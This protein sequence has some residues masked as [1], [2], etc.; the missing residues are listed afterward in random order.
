MWGALHVRSA[1]LPSLPKGPPEETGGRA[2][3]FHEDPSLL[4]L[5]VFRSSEK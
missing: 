3:V 4:C 2:L 5:F 1:D